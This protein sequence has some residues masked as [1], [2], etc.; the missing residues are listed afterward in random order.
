MIDKRYWLQTAGERPCPLCNSVDFVAF[1]NKMQYSLNLR[2]VICKN[3]ELVYTNPLPPKE[4][5]DQFYSD[6]Y[7]EYYGKIAV[8]LNYIHKEVVNPYIQGR[9]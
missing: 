7:S 6:A 1:T 5:Y 3:C 9:L 4:I 8:D 2:T